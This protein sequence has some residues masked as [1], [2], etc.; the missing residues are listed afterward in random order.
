M[1]GRKRKQGGG[2]EVSVAQGE[3]EIE[4]VHSLYSL[5]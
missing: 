5:P 1:L 3:G 2:Q 4:G